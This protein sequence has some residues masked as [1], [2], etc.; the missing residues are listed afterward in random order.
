MDLSKFIA[1]LAL[2]GLS[3]VTALLFEARLSKTY[4]FEL[5]IIFIGLVFAIIAISYIVENESSGW[6]I[7]TLIFGAG[8]VN[9]VVLFIIVKSF[10]LFI[11]AGVINIT[12]M[13]FSILTGASI[14]D[15]EDADFDVETDLETY[16]AE[17]EHKPIKYKTTKKKIAKKK[18]AKKKPVK[19]TTTKRKYNK[20]PKKSNK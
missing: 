15:L 6:F 14:D 12:G 8:L 1:F 20:N 2:L 11:L 9:A 7:A 3:F 5:V 18:P 17:E 19:K 10:S 4:I 13:I 16:T